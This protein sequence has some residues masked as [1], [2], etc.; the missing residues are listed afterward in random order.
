MEKIK[1]IE[2]ARGMKREGAIELLKYHR[3]LR[4]TKMKRLARQL[5]Q[6]NDEYTAI[7]EEIRR[8]EKE[9]KTSA[10]AQ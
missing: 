7:G 6:T 8:L 3:G 1:V 4:E 9:A 10:P 5:A 2:K